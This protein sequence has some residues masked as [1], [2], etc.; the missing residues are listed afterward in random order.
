MFIV[1][2]NVYSVNEKINSFFDFFIV[3]N[4]FCLTF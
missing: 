3:L 1:Y 2:A 4:P